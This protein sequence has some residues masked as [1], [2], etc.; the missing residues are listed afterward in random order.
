MP[1]PTAYS[2]P[3][4][5]SYRTQTQPQNKPPIQQLKS[6]RQGEGELGGDDHFNPSSADGDK[7]PFRNLLFDFIIKK[8]II[9]FQ[10]FPLLGLRTRESM[11]LIPFHQIHLCSPTPRHFPFRLIK[12]PQ[13][14]RINMT[15]SNPCHQNSLIPVHIIHLKDV[16]PL[17]NTPLRGGQRGGRAYLM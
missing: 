9:L 7:A 1:P 6:G 12:R 2:Y 15:M 14:R 17:L 11:L 10:P 5:I 3:A 13:P 4:T 8:W 16:N